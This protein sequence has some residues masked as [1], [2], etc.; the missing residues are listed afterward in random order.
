MSW[1][2]KPVHWPASAAKI[3]DMVLPIL[4]Q[5]PGN[6]TTAL[7]HLDGVGH[8]GGIPDLVGNGSCGI[9]ASAQA[10]LLAVPL[11]QFTDEH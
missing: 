1:T 11:L 9:S 8:A 5:I 6:S 4:A 10:K 3:R 7:A 2:T